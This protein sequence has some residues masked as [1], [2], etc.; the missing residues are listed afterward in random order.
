MEKQKG[1]RLKAERYLLDEHDYEISSF[2]TDR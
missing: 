1:K 2:I